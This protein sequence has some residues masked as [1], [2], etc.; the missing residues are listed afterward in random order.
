MSKLQ[1]LL[2]AFKISIK[3]KG[4]VSMIVSLLGFAAALLPV[5]LAN[6][7]RALTDELQSLMGTKGSVAPALSIFAFIVVLFVAQEV[8]NWIKGYYNS[9][10]GMNIQKYI[11]RSILKH[12]CEVCYKYIENYDDFQKRLLSPDNMPVQEWH[13]RL[14]ILFRCYKF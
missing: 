12:K 9:L 13:H 5:L 4:S 10:D 1:I 8:F 2:K 6:R 3:I 11:G 14:R 7:L